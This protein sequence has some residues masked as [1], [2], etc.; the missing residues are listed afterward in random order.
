MFDDEGLDRT[1][2]AFDLEA[3]AIH[4]V[5]NRGGQVVVLRISGWQMVIV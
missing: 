2:A 5:E 4:H 1:T 3:E